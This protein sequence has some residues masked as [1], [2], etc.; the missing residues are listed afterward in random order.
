MQVYLVGGAVQRS[1]TWAPLSRK[2]LRGGR[3]N[4]RTITR[5]WI[6]TCR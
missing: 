4:T 2:R 6:S 5:R 1:F 3:S